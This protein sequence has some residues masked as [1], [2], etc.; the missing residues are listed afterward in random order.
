MALQFVGVGAGIGT[1]GTLG[2]AIK[3][4]VCADLECQQ[5][6]KSIIFLLAT[7]NI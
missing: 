5:T 3:K 2:N 7:D 1:V 4:I 6:K